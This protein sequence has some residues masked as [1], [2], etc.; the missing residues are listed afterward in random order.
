MLVGCIS[1]SAQEDA[2]Y[3]SWL[4]QHPDGFVTNTYVKPSPGYL[5][6]RHAS[7]LIISR[8]QPEE[9]LTP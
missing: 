4:A 3:Q 5:K 1:Q 7:W 2:G 9:S 8:L 6:L